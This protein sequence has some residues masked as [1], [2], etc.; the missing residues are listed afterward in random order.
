MRIY[1][2]GF[3][4]SSS[5]ADAEVLAGCL[6]KA[7]HRIVNALEDAE[8]VVYNTC[9]VKAPTENRMVDL[10]KK[11]SEHKKL[12]VAGCL[13]MVNLKRLIKETRFD[14]VV[15]PAFGERIVNAVKK[16]SMGEHVIMLE[17]A[18]ANM[19]AVELPRVRVNPLIS[20]IPISYGCLGSCTYCCVNLARG[21]LRSY[22]LKEI[23]EKVE[24]EVADGVREFWLTSQDTACYGKDIGI[25]LAMLL[26]HVC[27]VDGDFF[28]R[29]GM[30]TPNN[31]LS[32]LDD[33][34][35][36]FQHPKVFKF[37]HLP[38]QS[39]DDAILELMN[40][41]YSTEDFTSVVG[42]FRKAF[43]QSTMA[44]DVIVGFPGETE[45][46]FGHTRSL[47]EDV[48]PDIVNVSKFFPRRGT[49][50]ASSVFQVSAS[51]IKDRSRRLASLVRE[52]AFDRNLQW[53]GWSGKALIDE[54][55]KPKSVVSRNF[56]YKP[57]AIRCENQQSLLGQVVKVKV[58]AVY[59]SHLLGEIA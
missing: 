52:I 20:I 7:G 50:A 9:A 23:L 11:A 53:S 3:G 24:N 37:L 56:A 1:V 48:T 6:S 35:E 22:R 32:I 5:I 16:V 27:Q 17:N 40:R 54:R 12:V 2:K 15:G 44:T 46:A 42:A 30:M 39:G 58:K 19:P 21:K 47:I 34:I 43:P 31:L 10:L 28:V 55:G 45:E 38:V 59:Q 41:F 29:V 49:A 36:A 26:R 4:C 18:A 14:G 8:I 51:T 13:P 33:L 25:N 57:I